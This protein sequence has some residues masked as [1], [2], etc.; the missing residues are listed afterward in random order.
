MH[1]LELKKHIEN[2]CEKFYLISQSKNSVKRI[3]KVKIINNIYKYL[4]TAIS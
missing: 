3:L 2:K 4:V 1:Q